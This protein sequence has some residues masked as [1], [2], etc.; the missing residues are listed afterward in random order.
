MLAVHGEEVFLVGLFDVVEQFRELLAEEGADDGRRRLVCAETMGIGGR[1]DAGLQQSVVLIDTH[2]RLDDEGGEAQVLFCR[3]AGSVEQH[4]CIGR[5]TPVVVFARA[6]DACERLFVQ[7]S[8]EAMLA[9]HALHERHEQHVVV[10]GEVRVL[11]DRSHLELV[12]SYLVMTRLHGDAEHQGLYLKVAHEG[13]HALRN[14]T[15]IVVVHLLV[16][17]RVVSHERAASQQEVGTSGIETF[18]HEEV[19]LL[20]AEIAR[21]LLHSRVE[22]V[23][24]LC[25]S[26]VDGFQGTQEGR[27]VVERLAAIRNEY[28]RDDERVVDDEDRACRVPGRVAA[29]L[30][31][32]VGS[33]AE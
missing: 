3:L 23:A 26:H 29:S 12:G 33:Q 4:A 20:P 13:C 28:C 21:H 6:V 5:E 24:N 2:Q 15:E 7:Q 30:E 18:I 8:A 11:E 1:H 16:L 17:G 25:C 10:N 27:F 14:A 31:G 32:L 19:F 9:G 22:V